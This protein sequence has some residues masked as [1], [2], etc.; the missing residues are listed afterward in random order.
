MPSLDEWLHAWAEAKN[1]STKFRQNLAFRCYHPIEF[2]SNYIRF[3]PEK[4]Q[5]KDFLASSYD[6]LGDFSRMDQAACAIFISYKGEV[7]PACDCSDQKRRK[8]VTQEDHGVTHHGSSYNVTEEQKHLIL[9]IL[10]PKDV[11]LY[12]VVQEVF[13][14]QVTALEKKHNFVMC[15]KIKEG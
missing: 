9:D 12:E 13:Q 3:D 1:N 8:L 14:E 4:G 10:R 11:K 6:I 7:P 15:N 2:E 5:G